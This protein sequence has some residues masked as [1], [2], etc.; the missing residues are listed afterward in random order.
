AYFV[1]VY[2]SN[3]DYQ[4]GGPVEPEEQKAYQ[5]IYHEALREGRAAGSVCVYLVGPT[6]KRFASLIVSDAAQTGRLQKFLEEAVAKLRAPGGRRAAPPP[7]Q[8]PPPGAG[9]DSLVLHLVSRY[10]HRGTWAEFPAEDYIVLK[11]AEWTK[12]LPVDKTTVG[13]VYDIDRD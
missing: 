4:P 11:R 6:G 5:Q 13:A 10:E 3:E 8:A 7:A 12:L 9:A 1:P 2:V